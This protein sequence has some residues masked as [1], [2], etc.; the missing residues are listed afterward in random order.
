ATVSLTCLNEDNKCDKQTLVLNATVQ[1]QVVEE[2]NCCENGLIR[3][4]ATAIYNDTTYSKSLD[5]PVDKTSH[6]FESWYIGNDGHALKC[7]VCGVTNG[8]VESHSYGTNESEYYTCSICSYV[9]NARKK[10]YEN[11]QTLNKLQSLINKVINQ[12]PNAYDEGTIRDADA[13]YSNLDES[14]KDRIINYD[15]Y[16]TFK[17]DY[18]KKFGVIISD[19]LSSFGYNLETLNSEVE[20][21][22]RRNQSSE[23]GYGYNLTVVTPSNKNA[24][25]IN[26]S[27]PG[28]TPDD[29]YQGVFYTRNISSSADIKIINADSME[30]IVSSTTNEDLG[31]GWVERKLDKS[32]MAN[33]C[34]DSFA[35]L[36]FQL[37]EEALSEG[38]YFLSNL[39]AVKPAEATSGVH[40][41][42]KESTTSSTGNKEYWV[43]DGREKVY[44][45]NPNPSIDWRDAES[46]T[47]TSSHIA[48][49][50]MKGTIDVS[51][52]S[53]QNWNY[54]LANPDNKHYVKFGLTPSLS[55]GGEYA[56]FRN[57]QWSD[58][59]ET[60]VGVTAT[61]TLPTNDDMRYVNTFK[62]TYYSYNPVS[63]I[64]VTI[65][66]L[67]QFGNKTEI[68]SDTYTH[69]S[70]PQTETVGFENMSFKQLVITTKAFE[71]G[72]VGDSNICF[73]NMSL[74]F[75]E[76][77]SYLGKHY[78]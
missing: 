28:Y 74:C 20:I 6:N 15:K 7:S 33:L 59:K 69:T 54:T 55:E 2:A 25:K 1:K 56:V 71:A 40:Y 35:G 53:E 8:D 50:P 72:K 11:N 47:L 65:E 43:Y 13:L 42:A 30:V 10:D 76:P 22:A 44:L 60:Q 78:S 16:L 29:E 9:D 32:M 67:D 70:S 49:I 52:T 73:K 39:Y 77:I 64:Q 37:G 12:T 14:V 41:L 62:M 34:S 38:Q 63:P 48:F 24:L 61:Y 26:V 23:Y 66:A 68:L 45:S 21:K 18:S 46:E 3:Y 4:T 19:N 58:W 51:T 75:E 57:Y 31:N 27:T 5:Y 17:E 36:Y